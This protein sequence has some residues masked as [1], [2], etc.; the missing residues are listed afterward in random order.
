MNLK[1]STSI[2]MKS[3]LIIAQTKRILYLTEIIGFIIKRNNKIR[4]IPRG[5]V[6][7]V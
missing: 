4:W 5:I 6:R 7:V 3:T 2:S 1:N